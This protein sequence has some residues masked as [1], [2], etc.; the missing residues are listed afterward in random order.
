MSR[1]S[2]R[3]R[4]AVGVS[5]PVMTLKSVVLPAPFGPMRPVISTWRTSRSTSE[6]AR[7]PPNFTVT[8]F[9]DEAGRRQS[10]AQILEVAVESARETDAAIDL[11]QIVGGERRGRSRSSSSGTASSRDVVSGR[12][13]REPVPAGLTPWRPAARQ[14][15]QRERDDRERPSC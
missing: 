9:D 7:F 15:E 14:H 4:P 2:N 13:S 12:A 5:S 8:C 3:I 1:P 10:C 11:A 6:S